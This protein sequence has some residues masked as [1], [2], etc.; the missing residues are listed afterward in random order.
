MTF[1]RIAVVNR[2][3]A[4][5]RLIHAV[6]DLNA[7]TGGR[8]TQVV[9]LHTEGERRAMFVREADLA[10]NLGPASARP[11]LDL[12]V[13]EKALLE[14]GA[15][16]AW[17][18]WGFV[19][20]DPAFAEL[21]ERIGVTFIGPSAEAM[22]RLG[23]KIG[24]KIIAEEVGVPVAPWSGAR[25]TPSTPRWPRPRRSA[26]RSCS[27]RRP[28]VAAAASAGSAR[29][30]RWRTPT[31]APATR[32]SAPSAAVW[33]SSRAWSPAR[34]TSRSRSSP[35]G[36]APPGRSASVT[37][38]SSAATRRSSRSPPRRSCP[39]SRPRELKASA[40]RLALAVGYAGAGTVE[41]LY[42]PGGRYFAFLE[43]N[44]RLQVE[45]PITEVTTDTDLVKLQIHVASG[46]RLEGEP[47]VERGPRHRG[48]AQRRGPRPR[49]R[50][51]AR[52]DRPAGAA[53]RA[54]R[55]RR[56]RGRRGRHH[57]RRL[58]LD[59]RQDHRLR[60]QPRRGARPAAPRGRA[61]PPWSSRAAPPTRASSSTCS[62]SRRSST[63]RPTPA[64]STGC[65]ARAAWSR[66]T[67]RESRWWRPGSR[68]TRTRSRS[69]SPACWRPPA[70][71]GRRCST[72]SAGRS[73]SSCAAPS[74]R[75]SSCAPGRTGS[76]SPSTTTSRWTPRWSASTRT[77]SR[78]TVEGSANVPPHHR[79]RT[80]RSTSSRSTGR[81]TGS[82]ATRAASCA[83]RRP[84]WSSRRRRPPARRV[85]AGAPVLVLESMKMETVLPAPFAATVKELLVATGSQVETGAPLV[86]LE[87]V[88]EGDEAASSQAVPTS[89]PRT[90]SC[91]PAA[92][93][94]TDAEEAEH[95]LTDLSGMLLGYDLDPGN[96]GR[97]L[98]RI[99]LR[100]GVP[101][102]RRRR[103]PSSGEV[104]LLVAV[105]RLR[106]AEPQPAGR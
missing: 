18:G 8:A 39:R 64:G 103:S 68:P 94:A 24:S 36:R 25:W 33:C 106:R 77:A 86:R 78:L 81:P 3:E 19:A 91:R 47:P 66:A 29:T 51:R 74:T 31:S 53:R 80:D 16:A 90:S 58:R 1:R 50:A 34:A 62:T 89:R 57:P 85:T 23:D 5:M 65:A 63:A 101:R 95:E 41:F 44:T 54:R 9:A 48:P 100:S 11:Y 27:R 21:C 83:R 92:T 60:P 42:H 15:D 71:A 20:E 45:H 73:T 79:A 75:S 46:G 4:A 22:R 10:Y 102:R 37:A 84:P 38:P 56:H 32:R 13:L 97:T 12:A 52:A 30:P 49:L 82:A 61:R 69:R 96:E 88:A 99:P 104:S 70:A 40:E 17:V 7:E 105:R 6:R 72:R 2:G 14:T 43:V 59:D 93:S 87:P 28:V 67:T 35:T 98:G 55:P 26:T 76:G